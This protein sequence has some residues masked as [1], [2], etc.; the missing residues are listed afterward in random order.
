[1]DPI[2]HLILTGGEPYLRHDLDQIV[3]I[4]YKNKLA[5]TTV[6][7]SSIEYIIESLGKISSKNA[8]NI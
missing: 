5:E 6:K 3:K 8:T 4:F 7:T 1:M 2:L